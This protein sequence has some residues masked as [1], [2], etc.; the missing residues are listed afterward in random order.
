MY[1][2]TASKG[3]DKVLELFLGDNEQIGETVKNIAKNGFDVNVTYSTKSIEKH[4]EDLHYK[5]LAENTLKNIETWT[6]DEEQGGM[7]E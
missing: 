6:A 2:I 4:E 1:I 3:E 7:F 5:K